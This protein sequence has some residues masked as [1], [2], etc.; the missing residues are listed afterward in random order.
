MTSFKFYDTRC[1]T[2]LTH[3]KGRKPT[4]VVTGD[5]LMN[6]VRVMYNLFYQYFRKHCYY[7]YYTYCTFYCSLPYL[8]QVKTVKERML[9]I[10]ELLTHVT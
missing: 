2:A 8:P 10:T 4:V 5:D 7:H 3:P 6:F 1:E 9:K